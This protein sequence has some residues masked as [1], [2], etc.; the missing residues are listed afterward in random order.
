M[1]L[2]TFHMVAFVLGFIVFPAAVS[3]F[4]VLSWA[5][6][7]AFARDPWRFLG[8]HNVPFYQDTT[9]N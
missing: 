2:R 7:V 9:G 3:W 8:W 4:S 1:E 6:T 5:E